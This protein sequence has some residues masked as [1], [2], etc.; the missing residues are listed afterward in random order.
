MATLI[1]PSNV[2]DDVYIMTANNANN[3]GGVAANQ[4]YTNA[5]VTITNVDPTNVGSTA[6]G[7]IWFVY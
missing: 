4:H 3:L 2:T 1:K 7:H 5:R 6:N